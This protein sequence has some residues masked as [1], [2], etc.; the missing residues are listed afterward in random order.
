MDNTRSTKNYAA[1]GG[2]E[3][4]IGG[5]LTFLPGA[6]V[7]G[8]EGILD[9]APGVAVEPPYFPDSKATSASALRDDFNKLLAVLREVG[10][11]ASA[12]DDTAEPAAKEQDDA[13]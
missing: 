9:A 6:S 7:E 2:N 13:E 12:P 3:W 1:H 8:L 4:V 5:K 11:L 10:L